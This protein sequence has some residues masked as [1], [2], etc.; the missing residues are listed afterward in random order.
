MKTMICLI[1]D[2][3]GSMEGRQ[4]DVIGGVNSF[5]DE[6][7]KLPDPATIAFVR[8]DTGD[9]ERFRPMQALAECKHLE[10]GDF[11]PRGGTPLL[12][13]VGQT[14]A[15]LDE[16]WKKEQPERCIVVVVTD[17]EEN[18][19]REYTKE[20]LKAMIQAR[21]D[22][23]KWAFI[24]LGANVDAFHEASSMGFSGANTAGYKSTAMGT[25]AAYHT[26]SGSVA[27]MRA[28][29]QTM[30]SNLGGDI[31]EDGSLLN[32]QKTPVKVK[33]PTPTWNAPQ[34]NTS[35]TWTPPA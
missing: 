17:G 14:V 1:L 25:A 31:D 28:T 16:D 32:K 21:Q 34:N 7:K 26:V 4:N 11:Q 15:A 2:R 20:K 23:G 9:I 3:S 10:L 19:S 30:A 24:Y 33:V 8:F 27:M 13:A 5:I 22:S 29:G 6:Q 35:A 12:D 18:S